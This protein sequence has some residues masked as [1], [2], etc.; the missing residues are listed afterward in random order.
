[1]HIPLSL[2]KK[3]EPKKIEW[4]FSNTAVLPRLNDSIRQTRRD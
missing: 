4:K 2:G 1:M 3:I